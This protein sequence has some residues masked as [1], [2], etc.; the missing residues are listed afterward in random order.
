MT[1]QQKRSP[2]P[3]AIP[4]AEAAGFFQRASTARIL[5]F[6]I[7]MAFIAIAD[8]L[9][10]L[11]L[12]TDDLRWLYPVKIAAVVAVLW[13]YRRHYA[14]LAWQ[15]VRWTALAAAV[16]VGVLVLVLWVNLDAAW[17][18]MGVSAGFNPTAADGRIDWLLVTLRIAGAALVVPV[19]EEL[20]W[21]SF[22]MRWI[23]R[24]DFLNVIPAAVGLKA[25]IVSV[26]LFGV[27]HNL[28]LA[29]I[30]AGIAYSLLYM[31]TGNLWTA[32]LA[33]AVTNG[34]LGVWVVAT[35]NWTYW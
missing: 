11:G 7:Y 27:E 12:T 28:W 23:E 17:M 9:A 1:A 30:V 35:A 22:L 6:A 29:G 21:R 10:R 5:P 24:N 32:V 13:I 15:P 20:F 14:E 3:A 25:C 4:T 26:I 18:Q 19:M 34:L 2:T 31:R 33:H 8:L 16:A